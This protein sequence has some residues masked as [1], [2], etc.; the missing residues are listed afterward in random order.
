MPQDEQ[1]PIGILMLRISACQPDRYNPD[2]N[3]FKPVR[4]QTVSAVQSYS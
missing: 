1:H 3:L 4:T 2:E